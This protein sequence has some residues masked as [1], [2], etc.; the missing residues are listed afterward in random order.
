[1]TAVDGPLAE[2][3]RPRLVAIHDELMAELDRLHET[4]PETP[5]LFAEFIASHMRVLLDELDEVLAAAGSET[6]ETIG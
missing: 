1:M 6:R 5:D 2:E 3:L 4:P